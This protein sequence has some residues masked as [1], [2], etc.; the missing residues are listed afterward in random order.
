MFTSTNI[1]PGS[2]FV[3]KFAETCLNIAEPVVNNVQSDANVRVH[4]VEHM[5]GLTPFASDR[6]CLYSPIDALLD[7]AEYLCGPKRSMVRT[8]CKG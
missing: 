7:D 1:R 2:P 3:V 4:A 8:W 6:I 5:I